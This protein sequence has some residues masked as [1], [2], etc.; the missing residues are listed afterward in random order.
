[1][2]VLCGTIHHINQEIEMNRTQATKIYVKLASK[3]LNRKSKWFSEDYE[4][5]KIAAARKSLAELKNS[6]DRMTAIDTVSKHE[7]IRNCIF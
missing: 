3:S 6:I 4:N 7:I 1:M 5:I 2:V